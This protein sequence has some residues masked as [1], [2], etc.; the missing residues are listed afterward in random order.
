M[1]RIV[2]A[3]DDK[4]RRYRVTERE[5]KERGLKPLVRTA[6]ADALTKTPENKTAAP[7]KTTRKT[8]RK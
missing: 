4:G 3:V 6:A 1:D 7:K 8:K 5:M 2:I